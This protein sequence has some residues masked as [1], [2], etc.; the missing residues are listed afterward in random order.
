MMSFSPCLS[1]SAAAAG[2][3]PF[4]R[5]TVR[6]FAGRVLL[7][8]CLIAVIGHPFVSR[9]APT[10]SCGSAPGIALGPALAGESGNVSIDVILC[11]E[12]AAMAAIQFDIEYGA[13]LTEVN[14]SPGSAS[15]A[16]D[17]DLHENPLGPA[18]VR[19]VIAGRNRNAIPD[20]VIATITGR[21]KDGA[22]SEGHTVTA[23]NII[24]STPDGY[25]LSVSDSTGVLAALVTVS[26]ASFQP[27]VSAGSIASG[28]SAL[29]MDGEFKA[30]D[31]PLP[32]TLG[33]R[34]LRIID[35]Q[36]TERPAQLFFAGRSGSGGTQVNFYVPEGTAEGEATVNLLVNGAVAASGALTVARVA[37]AIFT[38]TGGLA[39]ARFLIIAPDSSRTERFI[40]DDSVNLWPVDL[41]PEGQQ[42]FLILFG[43]GVRNGS[44]VTAT[45]GGQEVPVHDYRDHPSFVGLDQINLGPLPRSLAG[46]GTV[47]VKITVD[48][49]ESNSGTVAVQ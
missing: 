38:V 43:T 17:K 44:F 18:I 25:A 28:F 11:R 35:S 40:Y 19:V 21:P 4:S 8:I 29:A 3:A 48:G 20:G 31:L 23:S 41:G 15:T 36:Q 34:S 49:V 39:A 13:A 42:V 32:T 2:N 12:F 45:L 1:S 30:V 5:G 22:V 10:G 33:D 46:A 26:G 14:V 24:G 37:P 27:P 16:A 7:L 47:D 6:D 9:A